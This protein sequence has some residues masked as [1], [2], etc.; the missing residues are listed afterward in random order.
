MHE[1]ER[2]LKIV[3]NRTKTKEFREIS[4]GTAAAEV[5]PTPSME[6]PVAH[7]FTISQ[8]PI[9]ISSGNKIR[10]ISLYSVD[11]HNSQINSIQTFKD[12]SKRYKI[13]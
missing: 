12:Y 9:I 6:N 2:I 13:R 5:W 8:F 3:K 11:K 7:Y 1:N 4:R 10:N